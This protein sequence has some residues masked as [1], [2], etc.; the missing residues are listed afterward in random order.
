MAQEC[1]EVFFL[2]DSEGQLHRTK[3]CNYIR[4]E[5]GENMSNVFKRKGKYQFRFEATDNPKVDDIVQR[6]G[7]L[8]K[9]I[10]RNE[11]VMKLLPRSST[12]Y[13]VLFSCAPLES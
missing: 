3:D 8:C 11:S 13:R 2:W 7:S 5:P 1:K 9:Q 12:G 4:V 6:V 10:G